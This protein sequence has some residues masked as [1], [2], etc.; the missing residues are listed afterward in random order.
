[1]IITYIK[2]H[3]ALADEQGTSTVPELAVLCEVGFL[4]GET[5]KV[6][7]IGMEWTDGRVQTGRWR[8]NIPKANIIERKDTTI[9]KAFPAPRKK[10][11]LVEQ[12]P[13]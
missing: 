9:R 8:L 11:V 12:V 5:D 1:M 10:K 13:V 6:V 7:Q 2:W 3:D 4:L